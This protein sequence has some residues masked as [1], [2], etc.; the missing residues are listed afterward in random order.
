MHGPGQFVY[1]GPARPLKSW[2]RPKFLAVRIIDIGRVLLDCTYTWYKKRRAGRKYIATHQS[3]P[4]VLVAPWPCCESMLTHTMGL[5]ALR[6]GIQISME[7]ILA[8]HPARST[9][10]LDCHPK[11]CELWRIRTG[12]IAGMFSRAFLSF[13]ISLLYILR[14][15]LRT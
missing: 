12:P 10:W 4:I 6:H 1:A 14:G 5:C 13:R 3:G 2:I 15:W 9:E 11:S 7:A 8:C